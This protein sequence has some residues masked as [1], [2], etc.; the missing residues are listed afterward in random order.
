MIKILV[1][2]DEKLVR[3]NI[4]ELL[5]EESYNTI[6][7]ENGMIGVGL[8]RKEMPDLI[9]SDIMMP[10]LDGYGVLSFLQQDTQTASIPLN[11]LLLYFNHANISPA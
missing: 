11:F 5:S 1:I 8:A 2:E 10:E 3:S 9:I 7:A 4:I 6:G